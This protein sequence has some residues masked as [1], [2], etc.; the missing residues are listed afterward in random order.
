MCYYCMEIHSIQMAADLAQQK[1]VDFDELRD[2]GLYLEESKTIL[3]AFE[4]RSLGLQHLLETL[5]E[6][7][8]RPNY[9]YNAWVEVIF[10]RVVHTLYMKGFA[11]LEYQALIANPIIQ[12]VIRWRSSQHHWHENKKLVGDSL[13]AALSSDVFIDGLT[14]EKVSK[15]PN[16]MHESEA[17]VRSY[18]AWVA[19]WREAEEER[20][21]AWSGAFTNKLPAMNKDEIIAAKNKDNAARKEHLQQIV[22]TSE[23]HFSW[24]FFSAMILAKDNPTHELVGELLRTYELPAIH[25][26]ELWLQR[27]LF[28]QCYEAVGLIPFLPYDKVVRGGLIYHLVVSNQLTLAEKNTLRDAILTSEGYLNWYADPEKSEKLPSPFYLFLEPYLMEYLG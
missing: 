10:C 9:L 2:F 14:W 23:F 18:L 4:H 8:Q 3:P 21:K 25:P 1:P 6:I 15:S 13:L 11:S 12:R 17:L 16:I 22:V 19:D 20:A 5:D 26:Q 24:L 7:E 28:H 27:R